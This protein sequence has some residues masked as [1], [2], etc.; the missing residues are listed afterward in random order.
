M[1][2]IL[3]HIATTFLVILSFNSLVWAQ[4][5]DPIILEVT[6][7][8][9]DHE[10]EVHVKAVSFENVLG[11]QFGLEFDDENLEFVRAEDALVDEFNFGGIN[12]IDNQIL[13]ANVYD[14]SIPLTV[15]SGT[16]LFTLVFRSLKESITEVK[17]SEM[18]IAFEGVKVGPTAVDIIINPGSIASN[19]NGVFGNVFHDTNDNCSFDNEEGVPDWPLEFSN[20][21]ETWIRYTD[22]NGDFS[23][24]LP[25]GSYTVTAIDPSFPNWSSCQD[26]V[27]FVLEEGVLPDE[28]FI[29][30]TTTNDCPVL[31]IDMSINRLRRCFDNNKYIIK[32]VNRGL[33]TQDVTIE[34]EADENLTIINSSKPIASTN[35][36]IYTFDIGALGINQ[37]GSI[38]INCN[39]DCDNTVLDQTLCS[40]ARILPIINCGTTDWGGPQ[41]RVVGDCVNEM[42]TFTVTNEGD[43]NMAASIGFNI[44]EDDL[45]MPKYIGDLQLEAGQEMMFDFNTEGKTIRFEIPQ[46]DGH[47]YSGTLNA[48]VEACG[49]DDNGLFSLGYA[50]MFSNANVNPQEVNVCEEI[51]GSWDPNDKAAAPLGYKEEHS[52]KAN[53]D[54]NY[55]IRFQNTGTDT[56]FNIIIRDT[57]SEHLDL[58]S[59]IPGPSS[60]SYEYLL[61]DNNQ[62][63]FYFENILLPDSTI[64]EEASNGYVTFYIGQ[65][66]DLEDGTK[67][68]NNAAIYFD[69]NEPIITNQ[70]FHTIGEAFVDIAVSSNNVLDKEKAGVKI[71]PNPFRATSHFSFHNDSH[72]PAYLEVL[73]INGRTIYGLQTNKNYFELYADHLSK[74]IYFYKLSLDSRLID[75]GKLIVQ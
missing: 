43:E 37:N 40:Q 19:G 6:D 74:G 29:G 69:F 2:R 16:K 21:T 56:A 18:L 70:V 65:K 4:L 45:I 75:S 42:A 38:E 3:K 5:N 48:F 53:T 67:I 24:A 62:L 73:D 63:V 59:L 50:N 27:S 1:N 58:R 30:A 15:S 71:S 14:A 20:G 68:Y 23:A 22:K 51:I 13:F 47:P 9:G 44:V 46:I 41:L 55:K 61:L 39:V 26:E 49:E 32:Y 11:M 72:L 12:V 35:G 36:N 28:I 8:F 60:H 25:F 33:P 10:I 7:G 64:N 66:P 57:L 17:G 34:F 54:I 31:E 52:L